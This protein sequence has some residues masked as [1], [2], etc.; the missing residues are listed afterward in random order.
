MFAG[1]YTESAMYFPIATM[2][3]VMV[4]LL[5]VIFQPFKENVS[6]VTTM[7]TLFLFLLALSCASCNGNDIY[8]PTKWQPLTILLF[9]VISLISVI[10]PLLYISAI[11]LHWMYSHRKFGIDVIAK[12]HA[13]RNGY[14]MVM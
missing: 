8:T 7:N 13:W 2:I 11:V 3:L 14:D 9:L 6:H 12:L 10:F 4:A 1:A 5:F